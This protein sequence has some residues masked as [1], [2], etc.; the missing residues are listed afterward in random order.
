[1]GEISILDTLLKAHSYSVSDM[2]TD[3]N[4]KLCLTLMHISATYSRSLWI[5]TKVSSTTGTVRVSIKLDQMNT[6]NRITHNYLR[7]DCVSW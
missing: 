1:M 3:M 2:T 4:G 5:W 6:A 7:K